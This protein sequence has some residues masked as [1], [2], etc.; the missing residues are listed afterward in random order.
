MHVTDLVVHA[1]KFHNEAIM[2]IHFSPRYKK[3][4]RP[5]GAHLTTPNPLQGQGNL[6]QGPELGSGDSCTLSVLLRGMP[7]V[8]SILLA[9]LLHSICINAQLLCWWSAGDIGSFGHQPAAC[10]EGQVHPLPQRLCLS[11][12]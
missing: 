10:A 11:C 6:V 8:W 2:L 7:Y 5:E 12:S 1:H 3:Q 9:T 4:V